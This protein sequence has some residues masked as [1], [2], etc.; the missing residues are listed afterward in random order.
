MSVLAPILASVCPTRV[1]QLPSIGRV[2]S[3]HSTLEQVIQIFEHDDELPGLALVDN[4]EDLARCQP[5]MLSR[6]RLAEALRRPYT[7]ELYLRKPIMELVDRL[8][9]LSLILTAD[10]PIE[11]AFKKAVG[12][13]ND[14]LSEPI[15]L[16]QVDG[17]LTMID[18]GHLMRAQCELLEYRNRELA[19]ASERAEAANRA[20]SDFLAHMSHEIRT[21]M[22]AILGNAELLQEDG[23]LSK[24]PER[25]VEAVQTIQRAGVHL[26]DLINDILDVSKVEAGKLELE[27]RPCDFAEVIRDVA[28]TMR[29]PAEKKGLALVVEVDSQLR[30]VWILS[31]ARRLKQILINLIGNAVKFTQ[32]G[33]ITLRVQPRKA[34]QA[35]AVVD[36][37]H[38]VLGIEISVTDTGEGMSDDQISR[39]FKPFSQGDASMSR[40]HGGTGLGLVISRSI[41]RLMG[42][43]LT[44][45]SHEGVGS[46]FCL[47]IAQAKTEPIINASQSSGTMHPALGA[48]PPRA[49]MPLTGIRVLLAEDG[50]DNQRLFVF[51]LT[52]A[53]ATVDLAGDGLQAV[54]LALKSEACNT[55]YHVV[56]MDM[57]MPELDGYEATARLRQARY[58][59]PIIALTAHA[60][61]SELERCRAAG[62]DE[63]GTKPINKAKLVELCQ[64]WAIGRGPQIDRQTPRAA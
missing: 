49:M 28:R 15:I 59:R 9:V 51:H 50:P 7:L 3:L 16:R 44:V 13:G 37:A 57:Q 2:V 45:T 4:P 8:D 11:E 27:S 40:R 63:V 33:Q 26:L 17:T 5:I 47:T 62:C 48:T 61:E 30:D 35:I 54:A 19:A 32:R 38:E 22:T 24:A 31:D 56:L 42:G 36:H 14:S 55:P 43:D 21:P 1:G 20:K 10:E 23:D 64:R 46:T 6:R 34:E 12:R 41:A 52:R 53:G 29:Q 25:R 39:L 60:L 58:S 18:V